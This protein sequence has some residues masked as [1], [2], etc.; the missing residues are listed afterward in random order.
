MVPIFQVRR[1]R[2]LAGTQPRSPGDSEAE[3]LGL[4]I[5]MQALLREVMAAICCSVW[6]G[7]A[8]SWVRARVHRPS[9]GP[10]PRGVTEPPLRNAGCLLLPSRG[11]L[12]AGSNLTLLRLC[13]SPLVILGFPIHAIGIAGLVLTPFCGL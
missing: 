1:L 6:R 4:M 3:N 2:G 10:V 5:L 12:S 9:L 7:E 11:K 13:S 8:V